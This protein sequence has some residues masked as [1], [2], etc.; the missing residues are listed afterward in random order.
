[1]EGGTTQEK[2]V[3]VYLDGCGKKNTKLFKALSPTC[4]GLEIEFSKGLMAWGT[5]E[6]CLK[7]V[8]DTVT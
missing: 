2:C 8:R 3:T 7:D 4:G 6:G 1:M 5:T